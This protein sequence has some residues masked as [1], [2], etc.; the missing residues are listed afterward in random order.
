MLWVEIIPGLL[1]EPNNL[2]NG[3]LAT[4]A[5][6]L[7]ALTLVLF[8]AAAPRCIRL[9]FTCHKPRP[10]IS[11]IPRGSGHFSVRFFS[12]FAIGYR[13]ARAA[14]SKVGGQAYALKPP[15]SRWLFA[16]SKKRRCSYVSNRSNRS[17]SKLAHRSG[18]ATQPPAAAPLPRLPPAFNSQHKS[19]HKPY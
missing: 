5:I 10:R 3:S 7:T 1:A 13:E 14:C 19:R 12:R 6:A 9:L 18:P 15:S 2:A 16:N 4:S 17:N 8:P 11:G